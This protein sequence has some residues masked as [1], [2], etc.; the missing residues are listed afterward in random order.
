MTVGGWITFIA[1]MAGFSGLFIWCLYK[2]L[3]AKNPNKIHGIENT[4]EM[5][6]DIMVPLPADEA[7]KCPKK[8]G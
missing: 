4:E 7:K 3:T 6:R 8:G 2:V 1:S 5:E